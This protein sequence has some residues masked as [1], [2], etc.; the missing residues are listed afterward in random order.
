MHRSILA[1]LTLSI[2]TFTGL[3][4]DPAPA[5]SSPSRAQQLAAELLEMNPDLAV[6]S[7]ADDP[8]RIVAADDE[9]QCVAIDGTHYCMPEDEDEPAPLGL[10]TP[11]P[12]PEGL[13][14]GCSIVDDYLYC[15]FG[16][17]GGGGGGCDPVDCGP[18]RPRASSY[19]GY[20]EWCGCLGWLA[21]YPEEP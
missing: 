8:E 6:L 15:D 7:L 17:G 2:V 19:T 13:W 4:C 1:T 11:E 9:G 5:T 21:C 20:A 14:N 10:T 16:S 18:C 3:G 12:D